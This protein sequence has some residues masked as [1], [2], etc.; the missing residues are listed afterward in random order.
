MEE[1]SKRTNID[2]E[3]SM[4]KIVSYA[5]PRFPSSVVLGIVGFALFFLYTQAYNLRPFLASLAIGFGYFSIAA[6]QFLIGWISDVT[7]TKLGRRK[8]YIF[9]LTPILAISFIFLLLPN[10]FLD[11]PTE[12]TLFLWLLIWD[13]T[14]QASYGVTTPYQSWMAEQFPTEER[15]KVSQYQNIFNMIGNGLMA[16]FSFVVLTDVKDKLQANPEVIPLEFLLTVVI[17]AFLVLA[18]FYFSVWNIETE[19]YKEIQSNMLDNLKTILNNKNYLLVVFM[20]G[21]A[22]FAWIM[23]TTIM[24]NFIDIVLAFGTIEY[25]IAAVILLAGIIGFLAI[26]KRLIKKY[27]KKQS[28]LYVYLFGILFLPTSLLGLLSLNSLLNLIYGVLFMLGIAALL[29]GWFLFPYIMYADLAEDDEVKTKEM[30]AGIY[31]GFPSI[32]LN[33]LQAFGTMFLGLI[34]EL[35]SLMGYPFSVGYVIWGPIC[36]GILLLTFVY[37]KKYVTLDYEWE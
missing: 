22:S 18:F 19:P 31:T 12:N 9:I 25:L 6:S 37:T 36:S 7:Y 14:F 11:S 35:P 29:G 20:Q 15:P 27:G 28:L 17:F 33:I 5:L 2:E 30:K 26:W 21:I 10:L 24:L 8:P 4:K 32:I 16:I 3:S 34:L 13:I 23:V 1:N